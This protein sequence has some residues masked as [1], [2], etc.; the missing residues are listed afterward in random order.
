M[1]PKKNPNSTPSASDKSTKKPGKTTAYSLTFQQHL[2]D[3]GVYPSAYRHLDGHRPLKPDNWERVQQIMTQPR[4]SL[5]PSRFSD[6]AF[7]TYV[8][9]HAESLTEKKV[10]G[11]YF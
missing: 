1:L 7:E 3:H 8:D 4:P 2:I 10:L 11:K 6:E 5:S 9:Q